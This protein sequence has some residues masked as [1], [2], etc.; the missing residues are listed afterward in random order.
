MSCWHWSSLSWDK[1]I[2]YRPYHTMCEVPCH[3]AL[4]SSCRQEPCLQ[5]TDLPS[6]LAHYS[7]RTPMLLYKT[8]EDRH[9][10]KLNPWMASN[11]L[12]TMGACRQVV[13]TKLQT[14]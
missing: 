12:F 13:P 11:L 8:A 6:G 2:A 5:V 14:N 10:G 9:A 3:M 1:S 4:S 7:K